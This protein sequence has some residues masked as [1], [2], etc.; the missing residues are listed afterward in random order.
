VC[1]IDFAVDG[2]GA[3]ISA[4]ISQELVNFTGGDL[5]KGIPSANFE[6]K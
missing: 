5:G 3:S 6:K 1:V 4:F 2:K